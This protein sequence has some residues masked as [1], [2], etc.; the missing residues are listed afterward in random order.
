MKNKLLSILTFMLIALVA[1]SGSDE[2]A[3]KDGNNVHG[4]SKELIVSHFLP[5]KHPIQTNIL[6]VF[7][8]E[9]ESET[10]GEITYDIYSAGALGDPNVQ[11]DMAVT[12]TADIAMSVH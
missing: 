9:L 4:E 2:Q 8:K 3:E 5:D 1:C 11:Y 12:G 7:L 6:E 10:N